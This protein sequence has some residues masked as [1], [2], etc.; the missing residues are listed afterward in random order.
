MPLGNLT[1]QFFANVY[2]NELDQYAKHQL[3]AEYYIRYVDDFVI[4]SDNKEYLLKYKIG[5][6]KFLKKINL[7]LHKNKTKI[8]KINNGTCFLGFR[9]FCYHKLLKKNNIGKLKRKMAESRKKLEIDRITYDKI[10]ANME[11]WIAHARNGNTYKLRKDMINLYESNFSGKIASVEI[12]R[13]LKLIN[14]ADLTQTSRHLLPK[15]LK[16]LDQINHVL[17]FF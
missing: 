17:A 3:K 10:Y 5:I 13:L 8:K 6:E 14:K 15:I 2:L 1:S 11:G 16:A 12:I 9:V 7:E 4:F